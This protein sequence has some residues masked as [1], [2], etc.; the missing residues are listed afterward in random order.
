MC[1]L[2]AIP[3]EGLKKLKKHWANCIDRDW[4]S[5]LFLM[6]RNLPKVA[7]SVNGY[8]YITCYKRNTV[9][10]TSF[11][12][13]MSIYKALYSSTLRKTPL[14]ATLIVARTTVKYGRICFEGIRCITEPN[15]RWKS[16]S[17]YKILVDHVTQFL[18][19]GTKRMTLLWDC[20]WHVN[21]R[22]RESLQCYWKMV[23]AESLY[24]IGLPKLHQGF[25]SFGEKV[26][27]NLVRF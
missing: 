18:C 6:M 13:M 21:F 27:D 25:T 11:L 14:K 20:R 10:T 7:R 9:S 22:C 1:H 23:I 15:T 12:V 26:E 16:S 8:D 2:H 5:Y 19:H 3:N 24:W 17:K 4:T